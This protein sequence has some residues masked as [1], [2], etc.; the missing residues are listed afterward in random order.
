M[1]HAPVRAAWR[2]QELEEV[3]KEKYASLA[4]V[5]PYISAM[6]TLFNEDKLARVSTD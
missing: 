6:A 3:P 5:Y 2:S 4:L 1:V